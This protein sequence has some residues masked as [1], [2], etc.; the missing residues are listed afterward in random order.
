MALTYRSVKG[1]ALTI[2]EL[3]DN[4]RYFTGSHSVTGSLDITGSLVITGSVD[5]VDGGALNVASSVSASSLIVDYDNVGGY[6]LRITSSD[7]YETSILVSNLPNSE[8]TTTGSFWVS[9]SAAGSQSGSQYLMVF[10]G[11]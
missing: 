5:L 4:F 1:S 11:V 2:T 7:G 9:G 3:D 10:T 8:V 6:A